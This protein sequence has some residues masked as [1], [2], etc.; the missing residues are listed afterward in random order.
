MDNFRTRSIGN[1]S[2]HPEY[3]IRTFS[4]P[5]P[6]TWQPWGA[7]VIGNQGIGDYKSM[8]DMVVPGFSRL[9]AKG[10]RLPLN[11][12][13]SSR[14]TN[15]SVGTSNLMF[16]STGIACPP[17]TRSQA[18][19]VG[20]VLGVLSNGLATVA[21]LPSERVQ[22]LIGQVETECLANRQKGEA[23]FAES[24]AE[25]DQAFAL[26]TSPFSNLE[27]FSRQFVRHEN[28][29]RLKKLRRRN[30]RLTGRL[31][32]RR[33]LL[34]IAQLASS[35]WLRFRYGAYPIYADLRAAMKA[36]EE[37]YDMGPKDHTARAKAL[38]STT[39]TVVGSFS[40][41]GLGYVNTLA[42]HVHTVSVRAAWTDRY[43]QTPFDKLGLTFGNV[44]G[45]SWELA[46]KSFVW[47]WFFNIGDLIYANKPSV[48][49]ESF[50]G[51]RSYWDVRNSTLVP[52]GTFYTETPPT[53]TLSGSVSDIL[54]A[55]RIDKQRVI[56]DG[57]TTFVMKDDFRLDHWMRATD[58]ASLAFQALR[59]ISF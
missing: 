2:A 45:L 48:G 39:G 15:Q 55:V 27:R 43:Q 1:L 7:P 31:T 34:E 49:V 19:C 38:I 8:R 29:K 14:L 23:N 22:N 53:Y 17:S 26:F 4:G 25:L 12:M 42:T 51:T 33:L 21:M 52:T 50:G 11:E 13:T 10:E 37:T 41:F 46:R 18:E 3:R 5:C 9:K 20:S 36:L 44:M 40:L 47:D 35:E 30:V 57:R 56:M 6:L 24:M 28:Y 59:E 16:T 32:R 54:T 58:A